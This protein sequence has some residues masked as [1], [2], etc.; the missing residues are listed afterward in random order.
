MGA[1]SIG[2]TRIGASSVRFL[3]AHGIPPVGPGSASSPAAPGRS[4]LAAATLLRCR[5]AGPR[6]SRAEKA[7]GGGRAAQGAHPHS[8]NPRPEVAPYTLGCVF[9]QCARRVH[10]QGPQ[11]ATLVQQQDESHAC[12]CLSPEPEMA[13]KAGLSRTCRGTRP[14][15]VRKGSSVR[16]R[17]R[18]LPAI[19]RSTR[20]GAGPM[21]RSRVHCASV[22]RPKYGRSEGVAGIHVFRPSPVIRARVRVTHAAGVRTAAA[23][24][25]LNRGAR[26][27]GTGRRS[28]WSV[29]RTRAAAARNRPRSA[30]RR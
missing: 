21:T 28:P 1:T 19:R 9:A 30:S 26:T 3:P 16:V 7:L 8:R 23:K 4:L 15:M 20:W 25:R 24:A 2:P 27:A 5:S 18:A 29:R 12:S 14:S 11:R 6:L 13:A 22:S 17:Q 10:S